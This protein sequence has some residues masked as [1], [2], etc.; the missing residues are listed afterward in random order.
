MSNVALSESI[1]RITCFYLFV[2]LS[3]V[4]YEISENIIC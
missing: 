1:K 3:L 4:N 2:L